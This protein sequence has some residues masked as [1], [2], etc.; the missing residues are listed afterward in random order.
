MSI[1]DRT[2]PNEMVNVTVQ[3]TGLGSMRSV[4]T[5]IGILLQLEHSGDRIAIISDVMKQL[6]I[7]PEAVADRYNARTCGHC[8]MS[9]SPLDPCEC[10]QPAIDNEPR[11]R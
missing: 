2:P 6:C 1:H 11:E 3:D 9:D 8:G 5:Y 4:G 10:K 7:S